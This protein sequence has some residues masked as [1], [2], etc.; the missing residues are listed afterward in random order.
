MSYK[1]IINKHIKEMIFSNHSFKKDYI[2][3]FKKSRN[4]NL[5]KIKNIL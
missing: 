2:K 5:I 4:F 3:I 1:F